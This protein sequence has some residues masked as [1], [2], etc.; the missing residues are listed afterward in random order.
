MR[1]QAIAQEL[2][3]VKSKTFLFFF[4]FY[5]KS[6][7][8]YKSAV[9]QNQ[10][11]DSWKHRTA[12]HCF[13]GELTNSEPKV[14]WK[15]QRFGLLSDK[16]EWL[17]GHRVCGRCRNTGF[18]PE[19]CLCCSSWYSL[20]CQT[21]CLDVCVLGCMLQTWRTWNTSQDFYSY[22]VDVRGRYPGLTSLP[23]FLCKENLSRT[24]HPTQRQVSKLGSSMA[25]GKFL[26][27]GGNQNYWLKLYT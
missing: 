18:H 13:P 24:I 9:E 23:C 22:F 12:E 4:S 19:A 16:P 15:W 6:K 8:Y 26:H 20:Q 5:K 2:S 27:Y 3:R 21:M 7:I 11:C 10:H 14:N 1:K 17:D 25:L